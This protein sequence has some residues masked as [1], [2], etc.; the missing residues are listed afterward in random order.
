MFLIFKEYI[1][2]S[3]LCIFC[4]YIIWYNK[5]PSEKGFYCTVVPELLVSGVPLSTGAGL[6]AA[7]GGGVTALSPEES[8][9]APILELVLSPDDAFD[10]VSVVTAELGSV[11]PEPF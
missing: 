3:I 6:G 7:A 2:D 4:Q 10:P 1:Y 5:N 9:L 11:T 8:E